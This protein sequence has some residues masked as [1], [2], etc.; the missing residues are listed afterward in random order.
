MGGAAV[1]RASGSRAQQETVSQE[2]TWGEGSGTGQEWEGRSAPPRGWRHESSSPRARDGDKERME[3][4]GPGP[5]WGARVPAV[6][7]GSE[8][9]ELEAPRKAKVRGSPERRRGLRGGGKARRE[10]GPRV[11]GGVIYEGGAPQ[12][13]SRCCWVS[14]MGLAGG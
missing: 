7:D 3:H 13:G 9:G 11:V 4:I 2:A 8:S 1:D 6:V 14:K 5:G 12:G 10:W